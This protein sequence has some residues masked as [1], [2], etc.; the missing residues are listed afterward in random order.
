MKIDASVFSSLQNQ[1]QSSGKEKNYCACGKSSDRCSLGVKRDGNTLLYNCFSS[2]CP[3]GGGRIIINVETDEYI[4]KRVVEKRK[5]EFYNQ[6]N[7]F[8]K[9]EE[10]YLQEFGLGKRTRHRYKIKYDTRWKRIV[11]PIF[12]TSGEEVAYTARAMDNSIKWLHDRSLNGICYISRTSAE[13]SV[14]GYNVGMLVEDPISAI[15]G[16]QILPTIAL[17]GTQYKSKLEAIKEWKRFNKIDCVY[18]CLDLDAWQKGVQLAL[19]LNRNG[20]KAVPKRIDRDI[21]CFS[22]KEIVELIKGVDNE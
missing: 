7:K 5:V 15:V 8:P 16:G 9:I 17:L 3:V 12:N 22:E 11:F 6:I 18:V 14:G 20:I 10:E 21:K 19:W 1:E 2:G 13:L 4:E